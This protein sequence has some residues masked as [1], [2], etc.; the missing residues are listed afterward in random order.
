MKKAGIYFLFL[1]IMIFISC[2]KEQMKPKLVVGIV[3]DQMRYDYLYRYYNQYSEQGFK[4]LM[5]NGMNFTYAQYNYVPTYTGPGHSSI[6][7]GSTPYYHGIISNDWY[8]RNS[9]KN[10]YCVSDTSYRTIGADNKSGRVSPKYLLASTITDELRMSDN[11]L[12]RVFSVSIKDRAAVLPGGHMANAAY[13]YD[14]KTGKF[15]SSSYYLK[16]LPGWVN[17]FNQKQLPQQ[18]MK[19][20]WQLSNSLSDYKIAMPD[21]GPGEEDVFREGKTTFPHLFDKLTDKDKL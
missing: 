18:L 2:H 9:R 10:V 13:W 1:G 14:S 20:G 3:I 19:S 11:G 8:D 12:S 17:N 15:V 5:K 6:Y 7:T 16:E 4:R 21:S